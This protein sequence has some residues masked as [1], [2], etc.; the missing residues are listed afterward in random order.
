[1]S[2]VA[3]PS[4]APTP[5]PSAAPSAPTPSAAS[6]T[7]SAPSAPGGAS[8]ATAASTPSVPSTSSNL[9]HQDTPDAKPGD[10]AEPAKDP[11]KYSFK[12]KVHGKEIAKDLNEEELN[13]YLQKGFGSAESFQEAANIRKQ[14]Q[15]FLSEFKKDPFAAIKDPEL[16]KHFGDI[17]LLDLAG[18]KLYDQIMA[19]EAKKADPVKYELEE[20]RKYKADQEAKSKA[21]AE[22]KK[23]A[24]LE[25]FYE[26]RRQATE[27]AWAEEL[28]KNGLAG[29]KQF[30]L[31]MAK[32]GQEFVDNG[33]DLNPVHLVAELKNRLAEQRKVT[34][35]GLKG[36]ALLDFVGDDVVNE[37]LNFKLEELKKGKPVQE[38]IKAV[39]P[40]A[41]AAPT[42]EKAPRAFKSLKNF[43]E[44][45][46]ED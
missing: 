17:D 26:Q 43:R 16:A 2:E 40:V 28:T 14:F 42:D 30:I 24:E 9:P 13:L 19:D 44:W 41:P 32:I 4:A 27:K 45:Q 7:P 5:A 33:L 23:Q 38:P 18:K 6:A 46:T 29:N 1:M 21:D 11:F 37:I 39:D 20:L 35:G 3:A 36:K 8:D 22:A 12:G 34:M 31:E 15:T 25:S 10:A